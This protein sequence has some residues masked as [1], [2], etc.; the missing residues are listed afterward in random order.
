MMTS[1]KW[2]MWFFTLVVSLIGG[3]TSYSSAEIGILR[4]E[5]GTRR[6]SIMGQAGS[7]SLVVLLSG[8]P[9]V[10]SNDVNYPFRQENNLF[11]LTGINQPG[12]ALVMTSEDIGP[13]TVLFLPRRDPSRETWTGHMLSA[14]EGTGISGINH[15][16]PSDSLE[17]Y[18]E[19]IL[20]KL[21]MEESVSDS[22]NIW[23][24][25]DRDGSI[26]QLR[27]GRSDPIDSLVSRWPGVRV[28]DISTAFRQSRL[29]KSEYELRQIR[30]A[31]QITCTA[32]REV[33]NTVQSGTYEYQLEGLI[34]ATYRNANA[35]WGFPSIIGSGPNAT[36]LHYEANSRQMSEGELVLLDIGAE[37]G[38]YSADVTRTI[39]VGG[40]FTEEQR[41]IYQLVMRAQMAGLEEVRPGATIRDVHNAA[42]DVLKVGLKNLGLLTDTSGNQYR[43][44]FMHGTSHFIGLDVHDVGDRTIRFKPGM[45]LTVEPGVY[46]R[47]DALDFLDDTS[48]NRL[49]KEN[50]GTAFEQYKGIGVRIEDDVLVTEDGYELLSGDA[51]RT[52]DEIEAFMK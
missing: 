9:R 47:E 7:R 26:Q 14:Q 3:A 13:G 34:L 5:F 8:L 36:T 41:R 30:K 46:V 51:P 35:Q 23:L 48:D 20:D 40:A 52:I 39:P 11:Y 27:Y 32:H 44:W 12:T 16:L 33:L 4:E 22:M 2:T 21:N 28:K 1:T 45:V 43:T 31:I 25:P 15:V 49:F 37:V 24:I 42:R 10:F 29:V 17:V 6:A 18:L 38:H 50:I 19:A